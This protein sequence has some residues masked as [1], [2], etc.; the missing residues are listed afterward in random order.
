MKNL[1]IHISGKVYKVGFRYYLKQMASVKHVKGYVK[2]D[3]DHSLLLE[4]QGNENDIDEF[5][6]Y[7]RLGCMSSTVSEV[8]LKDVPVKDYNKFEIR[9]NE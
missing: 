8:L 4:V 9:E 7:C 2:Y 6:K 3:T 1:R 5:V